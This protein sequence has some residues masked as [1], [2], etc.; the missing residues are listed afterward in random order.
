MANWRDGC[1]SVDRSQGFVVIE[2]MDLRNHL[3]TR[4]D[5]NGKQGPIARIAIGALQGLQS[6]RRADRSHVSI[7]SI[8]RLQGHQEIDQQGA[9]ALLRSDE[10]GITRELAIVR[11]DRREA[12]EQ[13]WGSGTRV[14]RT[15]DR[16]FGRP[17]TTT[18]ERKSGCD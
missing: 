10:I 6:H 7:A 9:K 14:D 12:P 8:A 15:V 1:Y 13:E 16:T 18:G 4:V 17:T 3:S 11:Y 5:R 2:E